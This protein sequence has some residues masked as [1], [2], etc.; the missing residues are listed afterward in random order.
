M[1]RK[2]IKAIYPCGHN[3]LPFKLCRD[4]ILLLKKKY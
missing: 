4:G 1:L 3:Y 2:K